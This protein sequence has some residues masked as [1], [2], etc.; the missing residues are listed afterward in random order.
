MASNPTWHWRALVGLTVLTLASGFL[1]PKVAVAPDLQEKRV[2]A[3]L[4]AP[5]ARL[6]DFDDYRKEL[7][8]YVADQF[9]ARP[10]LIGWLSAARLP[11]GISGTDRVIIGKQGWMFYDNDS[12]LGAARNA[13][14]IDAAGARQALNVLAGRTEYLRQRGIKYLMVSPPQKEALYPQMGPYWFKASPGRAGM[15]LPEAAKA[16]AAGDLLYLFDTMREP[17]QSSMKLFSRHDTHWS[18][19]GA[20]YGYVGMMHRLESMGIGDGPR[21]LSDFQPKPIVP[22][23]PRD[24]SLMLG[25]SS[26]V[27]FEYQEYSDRPIEGQLT[28]IYLGADHSWTGPQ[29]ID[30]GLV[31]KPVLLM[32]RD[33]F[34]NALMPFLYGHFSRLILAH[35]QDGAWR[36]DLINQYHPDVVVIE[37]IESGI[38]PSLAEGPPPTEDAKARND[39]VVKARFPS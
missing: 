31:G 24:L 9:P 4:P 10:F 8:A 13:P 28:T 1:L 14:P 33:S 16:S 32:T 2:L 36:E 27:R 6:G 26:F 7:D 15:V 21:P 11:F 23:G 34:S 20:Y 19:L 3:T 37:V 12:H 39:A 5:M 29:V 38:L 17:A 30:T 25:V 35:N 22:W 18:G